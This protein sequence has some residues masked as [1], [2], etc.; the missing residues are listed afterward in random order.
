MSERD[1]T[2]VKCV[3]NIGSKAVIYLWEESIKYYFVAINI[4]VL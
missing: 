2:Q 1:R 3:Q 4:I